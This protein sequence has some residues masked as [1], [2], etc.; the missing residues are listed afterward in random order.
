M[1]NNFL[2]ILGLGGAFIN[3]LCFPDYIKINDTVNVQLYYEIYSPRNSVLHFHALD[4]ITKTYYAGN[5]INL[6]N[7]NGCININ[8]TLPSFARNPILWKIFISPDNETF[9]NMLAETGIST[10]ISDFYSDSLNCIKYPIINKIDFKPFVII[11]NLH[12]NLTILNFQ[13]LYNT[14]VTAEISVHL[15]DRKTNNLLKQG[16]T[17]IVNNRGEL[18]LSIDTVN[19]TN[20]YLLTTLIEPDKTWTNR[21]AEDRKYNLLR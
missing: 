18:F 20:Y 19:I 3:I 9:P 1:I 14:N 16:Q 21:L 8:L 12:K 2:K 6:N 10:Q 15:M 5:E 4:D 17:V 7:S 13:L 11:K